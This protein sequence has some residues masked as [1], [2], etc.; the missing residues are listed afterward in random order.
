M[1]GAG[2]LPAP[3]GHIQQ[4]VRLWVDSPTG[5][6]FPQARHGDR[7]RR[8]DVYSFKFEEH[9]S[10]RPGGFVGGHQDITAALG[11]RVVDATANRVRR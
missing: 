3:A 8:L 5:R 4:D 11:E 2:S 9:G 7:G 1:I 10:G 6:R